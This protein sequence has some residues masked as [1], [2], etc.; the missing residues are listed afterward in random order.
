MAFLVAAVV[1]LAVL[2]LANLLFTFGVIR[3]LREHTEILDKLGTPGP[4][5]V[6]RKPGESVDDF[7]TVTADGEAVSFAAANGRTLLAAFSTSCAP[8]KAKLPGFVEYAGRHPGGRDRVV[9][10]VLGD[11]AE[12]AAS[13]VEALGPV[14]RVIRDAE[15]GPAPK[16]IGLHGFPA[17]ALIEPDRTVAASGSDLAALPPITAKV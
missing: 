4:S 8:C 5:A 12:T 11:D 9:A 7:M 2:F 3:R 10:M 15:E 16:A 6:M 17:F 13:F 1:I 14:A